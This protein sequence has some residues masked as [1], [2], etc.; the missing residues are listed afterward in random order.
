MVMNFVLRRINIRI[1]LGGLVVTVL[2]IRSKV[3]GFKLGVRFYGMLKN[4]A[5]YERDTSQAKFTDI[6]R[7]VSASVLG[8]CRYLPELPVDE[9]GI[10][11]T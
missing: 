5:E 2:A 10:I 9:S 8:V 7:Q 1:V 11:R 3:Y 6:S 4:P